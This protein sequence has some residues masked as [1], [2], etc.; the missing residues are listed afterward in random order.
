MQYAN[1]ITIAGFKAGL[2][3]LRERMTQGDLW[4]VGISLAVTWM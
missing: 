3:T 1:D 4:L 2:A